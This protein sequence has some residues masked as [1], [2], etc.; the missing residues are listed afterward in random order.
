MPAGCWQKAHIVIC[1]NQAKPFRWDS[2]K[3]EGLK[4][5]RHVSFEAVI[6]E[7]SGYAYLVPFVETETEIFLKTI[8]PNRQATRRYLRRE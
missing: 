2:E 3:N 4:D 1:W 7:M 6:L 8:F 5:H